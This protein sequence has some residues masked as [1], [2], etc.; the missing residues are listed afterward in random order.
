MKHSKAESAYAVV[1]ERNTL[2]FKRTLPVSA[3]TVWAWL[4]E[5]SLRR[6]WFADGEMQLEAGAP[7]E[8]VWRND[9]LSEPADQIGDASENEHSMASKIVDLEHDRLLSFTWSN[10]D[11]VTFEIEGK[12]QKAEFSIV[13]KALPDRETLLNIAAGWH[14]HLD[15]LAARLRGEKPV[16]F[17]DAWR[18]LKSEYDHRIPE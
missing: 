2:I 14:T 15:I 1:G 5:S 7:F 12:G 11:G 13:H 8:L 4:T 17:Q 9:Q 10:T 3:Q 18:Q 16:P 6:Q